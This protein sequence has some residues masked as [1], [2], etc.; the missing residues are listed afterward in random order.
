[1]IMSFK[2]VKLDNFLSDIKDYRG[3]LTI[4]TTG[5]I[6]LYHPKVPTEFIVSK[7]DE[8]YTNTFLSNIDILVLNGDIFDRRISLESSDF[9]FILG[10]MCSLLFK[11]KKNNVRLIILEGTRSH[12]YKQNELFL[13]IKDNFRLDVNLTYV[14]ELSVVDLNDDYKALFV[15]DE[16]NY[17][18]SITA[19]EIHELL[20]NNNLTEVDFAFMHGMFRYQAPIETP[21]SHNEDFFESI[22]KYK[23]VINHIHTPSRRGK[24]SA[25]GSLVR[26]RHGEEEIKGHHVMTIKDGNIKEWFIETENNTIFDTI[27]ISEMDIKDVVSSISN[28]YGDN[29]NVFIRLK[30]SRKDPLAQSLHLIKSKLNAYRFTEHFI[31]SDVQILGQ[32]DELIDV[33]VKSMVLDESNVK[34]LLKERLEVRFKDSTV[35]LNLVEDILK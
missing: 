1:M 5:D 35:H 12:D 25:P 26:L 17:D 8:I 24:I 9:E 31:D 3:D 19:K 23:I 13:L 16:V 7:L 29:P 32:G 33:D 2:H 20:N 14:S 18:A 22:V 28:K 6:H 27:D 30:L 11:C 34:T 15:P 10:W 4:A 21:V